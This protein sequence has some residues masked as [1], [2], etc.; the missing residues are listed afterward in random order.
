MFTRTNPIFHHLLMN[1]QYGQTDYPYGWS[2][3]IED[4]CQTHN[5]HPDCTNPIWHAFIERKF[6]THMID[7]PALF[8]VLD[9]YQCTIHYNVASLNL[10]WLHSPP[11][12]V[13]DNTSKHS[14]FTELYKQISQWR[15]HVL[16]TWKGLWITIPEESWMSWNTFSLNPKRGSRKSHGH[17]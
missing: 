4:F 14:T 12:P 15:G 11:I 5:H 6:I 10:Q 17:N 2:A 9:N 1:G 7:T 13:M 3:G 16:H 8:D